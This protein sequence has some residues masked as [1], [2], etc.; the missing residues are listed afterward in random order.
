MNGSHNGPRTARSDAPPTTNLQGRNSA[1]DVVRSGAVEPARRLVEE[2]KLRPRQ[3]LHADADSPL[4]P[5]AEAALVRR[6]PP[7]AAYPGVDGIGKA[8]LSY[9]HLGSLFLLRGRH[10]VGQLQLS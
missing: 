9:G 5:P 7:A 1:H 8:H 3:D 4:L 2:E 10:G 6:P